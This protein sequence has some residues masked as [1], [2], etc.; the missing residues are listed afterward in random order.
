MAGQLKGVCLCDSKL[1]E[2][3]DKITNLHFAWQ[4]QRQKVLPNNS[5]ITSNICEVTEL[6]AYTAVLETR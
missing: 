5:V 1:E 3:T 4:R 2:E 6:T